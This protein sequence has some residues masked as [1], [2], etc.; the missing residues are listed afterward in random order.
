ML[1]AILLLFY[2][3]ELFCGALDVPC[4]SGGLPSYPGIE[5][6]ITNFP[7]PDIKLKNRDLASDA[8]YYYVI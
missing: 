4:C 8:A 5:I 1:G 2:A 3:S 7:G 6:P